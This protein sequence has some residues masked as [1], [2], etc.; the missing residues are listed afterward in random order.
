MAE[1]ATL[2]RPASDLAQGIKVIDVDTH[3]SEPLD[4]W[5]SRAPAKWRDRVPQMREIG[6]RRM[7]TID[8]NRSMG[9]GSASSVIHADGSKADGTEFTQWLVTQVHAGCSQVAA[10]LKVMD[11]CGVWAQILYP[12][13]M[14]FAGQGRSDA[15]TR[16]DPV[17]PELRLITTQIY[18]D[19]MG[20]VQAESGDRL[21]PMAVLP[22]WDIDLALREAERCAAMGMRGVNINSDPQL[23]GMQDLS[24]DYWTP[25]WEYCADKGLPI[26]F[27]IG[28]SDSSMSWYGD[29]P[30]PS[31]NSSAKLTLG[32]TMMFFSN[33]KV[34]S[35]L[36]MSGLL[37]RHPTL[38]F[39]SVESG[40]GWIPFLLEAL[41]YGIRENGREGRANLSMTPLEYFRRQIY[42]CFWFE[43]RDISHS[44]RQLGVENCMFETDFPHPTCLY[45]SPLEQAKDGL[46]LLTLDERRKVLSTNAARVYNIPL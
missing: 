5:T 2:A 7:W 45:P 20:E 22:W 3:F 29:S 23:H 27:H 24:G 16:L 13:V 25:L 46:M 30:W 21:L 36:I 40:I 8:G 43:K 38:K 6:G 26:N 18:N 15:G 10:R 9:T 14:G 42:A 35:N 28:A 32:G 33:A 1:T 4:L 31:L 37:E 44:I 12:N 41:E 19:A 17:E 11:E 34:I 39:V